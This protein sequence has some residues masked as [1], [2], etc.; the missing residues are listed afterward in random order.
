MIIIMYTYKYLPLW[1]PCS[2]LIAADLRK[3]AEEE[4]EGYDKDNYKLE[5]S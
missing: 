5:Y 3:L 1:H 4:E 2:Y